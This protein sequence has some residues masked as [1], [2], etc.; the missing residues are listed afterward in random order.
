M[1]KGGFAGSACLTA[2]ADARPGTAWREVEL[3]LLA[4]LVLGVYFTRLTDL[5][6]RGEESRWARVAHEMIDTGD[7]IVPRQQGEP[8]PDRPPLNS[9]AMILASR[10][11]GELDLAA[12][13]LPAVTATLLITLAIYLYSRV[14]LSRF[15]ALAAAAAYPTMAQVLHLGRVGESDSLLTLFLAAALFSWHHGFACRRDARLAWIAGYALAALA[16]LAKGPQGPIYFVAITTIYLA[17]RREWRFLF[18]SAHLAGIGV[19]AAIIGLW[20]LPFY[21]ELDATSARAVW[22]EGAEMGSR[23]DY[24]HPWKVLWHWV[25]YPLEILIC[26]MPWSFMLSLFAARWFRARIGAARGMVGFLLTAIAVAFPTCWLPAH[27]RTRYFM[28]LY[29][30][31]APLIGLAIER[32]WEAHEQGWWQRG[33][34]RFLVAGAALIAGAGLFVGTIP[35]WSGLARFDAGQAVSPGFALVY[36]LVAVGAVAAILWSRQRR[37]ERRAQFGVLA[38]AGFMGLTYTGVVVSIQIRNSNDPSAAV[39]AIRDLI[40][41]GERLVSLEPVHHLFAYYY[42]Q[43]IELQKVGKGNA[44]TRTAGRYFCYAIDPAF[45]PPK[46]AFEWDCVAEVSCDRTR[47]SHP[48]TKVVVGRR[49]TLMSEASSEIE[50]SEESTAAIGPPDAVRAA[51]DSN[52]SAMRK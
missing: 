6:I 24:S 21:W 20:Q 26:M 27:S 5:T 1:P 44:A 23:F 19:F 25:S 33:W 17:C 14:F 45:E 18:S 48:L 39:A 47:S 13:R 7:W 31:V 40:P 38:I 16:G 3:L 12:I 49:R 2:P 50:L 41:P 52:P 51:F 36:V 35:I 22:S 9:W 43:P 46:I 28:S 15:G 30:C 32:C 34:D 37:E 10:L 4:A 11:I 8:F 42:D 29:P